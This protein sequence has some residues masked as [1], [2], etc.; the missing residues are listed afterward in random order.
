[1]RFSNA[2]HPLALCAVVNGSACAVTGNHPTRSPNT[3]DWAS[4]R[5]G[6]EGDA[7]LPTPTYGTEK[8]VFQVRSQVVITASPATI[9][10][11]LLD[12]QS[13]HRWNSFVVDV[14]LPPDVVTTPDDLYI[15]AVTTFTTQGILPPM[16]TTSIEI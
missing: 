15:G 1:M 12:F 9:Y 11:T 14:T 5:C 3:I 10:N 6:S 16:N 2:L 13:Y 4:L 8:A 7:N